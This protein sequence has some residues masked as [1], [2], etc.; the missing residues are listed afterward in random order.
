MDENSRWTPWESWL[1]IPYASLQPVQYQA[2]ASKIDGQLLVRE[3]K[4]WFKSTS[5]P[6]LVFFG[7]KFTLNFP[8][9]SWL[10][11]FTLTTA[12]AVPSV[13]FKKLMDNLFSRGGEK[14]DSNQLLY[15]LK[16]FGRKFVGTPGK[17]DSQFLRSYHQPVRKR[18]FQGIDGQLFSGAKKLIQI[19]LLYPLSWT[20]CVELPR[21]WTTN[22]L[23]LTTAKR[24]P[25]KGGNWWT[26]FLAEG[27]EKVDSNS[28]SLPSP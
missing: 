25:P 16:F 17:V 24:L 4:S 14:V 26:I 3:W 27:G 19:K 9:E 2:F 10:H 21:R 12:S 28:T 15:P 18:S 7:R 6:L 23:R 5:L 1:T 8:L 13:R 20:K 11:N 22:F